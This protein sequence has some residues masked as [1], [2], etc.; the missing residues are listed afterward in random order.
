MNLPGRG[1]FVL[2]WNPLIEIDVEFPQIKCWFVSW[3]RSQIRMEHSKYMQIHANICKHRWLFHVVSSNFPERVFE[4][5]LILGHTHKV[6]SCH[7][8]LA[9]WVKSLRWRDRGLCGMGSLGAKLVDE[10]GIRPGQI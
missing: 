3:G 1:S 7:V 2:L 9:Q 5:T 4:T 10:P 6:T 8:T